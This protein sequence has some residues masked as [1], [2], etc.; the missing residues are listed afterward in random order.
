MLNVSVLGNKSNN[1]YSTP[2]MP[3]PSPDEKGGGLG[4]EYSTFPEKL[5]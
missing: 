1:D 4:T 2:P 3:V 5:T